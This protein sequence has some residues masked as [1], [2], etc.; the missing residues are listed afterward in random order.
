VFG[1]SGGDAWVA[2]AIG[3]A[4]V[5]AVVLLA[6]P[7]LFATVDPAVA[8]G[9]G[10][11]VTALGVVF[12][13]LVGACAAEATTAVGALL[14]VGLLAAPGAAAQRWTARPYSAMAL[15]VGLAVG[16]MWAGLTLSYLVDTLPP[17]FA[18][19]AVATVVYAGSVVSTRGR[20]RVAAPTG[21]G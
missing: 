16:S 8:S 5:A 18:I 1:L 17:S 6:R 20:R 14:L 4:V 3:A 19:L 10:V 13:A 2:A 12:L 15:S 7:L 21:D 11:P 9:R